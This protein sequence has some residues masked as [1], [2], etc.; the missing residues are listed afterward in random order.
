MKVEVV[1]T[2]PPLTR[3]RRA[4]ERRARRSGATLGGGK[5]AA[6]WLLWTT[7]LLVGAVTCFAV[8]EL[9]RAKGR[10]PRPDWRPAGPAEASAA[11]ARLEPRPSAPTGPRQSGL[12]G[13]RA[14]ADWK[15]DF[16][17]SPA[18]PRSTRAFGRRSPD[19]RSAAA[20][21]RGTWEVQIPV[22]LE[23]AHPL[24]A[25]SATRLCGQGGSGSRCR[26]GKAE[27]RCLPVVAWRSPL[28][29]PRRASRCQRFGRP[30]TWLPKG[31]G[32]SLGREPSWSGVLAGKLALPAHSLEPT[33]ALSEEPSHRSLSSLPLQ[34]CAPQKRSPKHPPGGDSTFAP[35]IAPVRR[36]RALAARSR[37][38]A[39]RYRRDLRWRSWRASLGPL[40]LERASAFPLP[41][42]RSERPRHAKG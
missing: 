29:G 32:S 8:A 26:F 14:A 23:V 7:G 11:T 18:A 33:E 19:T 12:V 37:L 31:Q 22:R 6:G 21:E 3:R 35:A 25:Q 13:S 30:S 16:A 28:G 20:L 36:G 38:S 15:P 10:H 5:V 39:R 27:P 2:R 1:R 42:G 41:S 17:V 4:A 34:R 24:A 40:L 9:S